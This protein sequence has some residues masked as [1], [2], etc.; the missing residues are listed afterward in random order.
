[1]G[2]IVN[3]V[4]GADGKEIK[5]V[6]GYV[7]K[8]AVSSLS[9]AL[10]IKVTVFN[11][12]CFYL[13]KSRKIRPIMQVCPR[14]KQAISTTKMSEHVRIELLD[15]KWKEQKI[16]AQDRN[17]ETNLTDNLTVFE[18]LKQLAQAR[19]DIFGGDELNLQN[20]VIIVDGCWRIGFF[21]ES[22]LFLR[23]ILTC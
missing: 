19:P 9:T 15:P 6:P 14:C 2:K 7:P 23:L 11:S 18:N 10:R 13:V 21:S 1:M 8:G 16:K 4:K 20:K 5:V 17:K 3:V 22:I 12:P